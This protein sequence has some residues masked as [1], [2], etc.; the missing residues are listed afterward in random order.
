MPGRTWEAV[1]GIIIV[2]GITIGG[3]YAIYWNVVHYVSSGWVLS[4]DFTPAY[5]ETQMV[6]SIDMDGNPTSS[7]Q[8][9][10]YPDTWRVTFRGRC[11]REDAHVKTVR[12]KPYIYDDVEVG[13]WFEVNNE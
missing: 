2:A 11:K 6:T 9:M 4:K 8:T 7:L 1:L 10:H 12:V 3:G 5:S 13:A